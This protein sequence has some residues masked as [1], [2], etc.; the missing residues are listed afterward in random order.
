[1]SYRFVEDV[2]IADVAFVASG[3]TEEELFEAAALALTNSMV[4]SLDSVETKITKKIKINSK[5]EEQLLH[6]F[7]QELIFLKDAKLLLFSKYKIKITHGKSD[8]FELSASL[9]GEKLD[10]KKHELL[11][12][13]KAVSWHRFKVEKTPDGWNGFVILDV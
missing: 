8:G 12:D 3:K 4:K 1:M 2:A 9:A 5:N 13:V 6:D 10:M 7:L 11:V